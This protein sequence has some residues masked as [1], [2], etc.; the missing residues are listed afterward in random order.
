M[1][2]EA[3]KS[4]GQI[5]G[6]TSK[7]NAIEKGKPKTI[8]AGQRWFS[9]LYFIKRLTR[10]NDPPLQPMHSAQI[11]LA[12]YGLGD[13]SKG[14]FGSGLYMTKE[15]SDAMEDGTGRVHTRHRIW[16]E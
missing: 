13:V 11:V 5:T 8:R 9:D 15:G 14:G 10:D 7:G 16:C 12:Q 4:S 2:G 1:G 3:E 6:S